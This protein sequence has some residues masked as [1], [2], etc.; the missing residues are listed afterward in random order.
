MV[1]PALG[2]DVHLTGGVAK[3]QR[4]NAPPDPPHDKVLMCVVACE[5]CGER[6]A[7]HHSLFAQD[8][9]LAARQATWLADKFVWDHIQE[10]HHPHSIE[11]PLA[12]AMK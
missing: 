8:A 6:F 5:K 1:T 12:A 2:G 9:V 11:L 7:I 4:K 3:R 10:N